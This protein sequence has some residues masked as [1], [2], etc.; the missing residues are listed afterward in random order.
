M[1]EWNEGQKKVLESLS[2]NTNILV[3]AAAG[4]G[5]TAV[6]VERI[7]QTLEQGKA[8]IDEIL[9]CT[10]TRAA[11]SQ[12]KSKI[13]KKL[14][15]L[16]SKDTDGRM[17]KQLT[18]A[19]SADIMTIDS[20]CGKI[21]RENFSLAGMD[22]AFEIYDSDEIAILKDEILD[23][24]F[25]E[26]YK[27]DESFKR[28][29]SFIVS[30]SIDDSELKQFILN[31]FNVSESYAY[32]EGWLKN[33]R[34]YVPDRSED[35]DTV[36]NKA[37]EWVRSQNWVQNYQKMY[38]DL[39][40]QAV[41]IFDE[42]MA[43]FANETDPDKVDLAKKL[44]DIYL[45]DM[46]NLKIFIKAETLKKMKEALPSKWKAFPNKK[47]IEKYGE[48]LA[49]KLYSS[50]NAIKE[51]F[52]G[53]SGEDELVDELLDS[54][55]YINTL[56]DVVE[57]FRT[58]L[59]AE[60]DKLKKY[61]FADIAHSAY[62]ILY[63]IEND[64]PSAVGRRMSEIY[65]YIY[66]DEYQDGNDLQENILNAVAR[67]TDGYISNVFM[68][69]DVKQSIYRFRLARPE[70]FNEKSRLYKEDKGG[71]LINLNMNYRSCIE[72]LNATN[73]IFRKIMTLEFGGIEY[74]EDVELK[75]PEEKQIPSKY[76]KTELLL[77]DCSE[78]ENKNDEIYTKYTREEIEAVEIGRRIKLLVEGDPENG[79]YPALIKNEN[80]DDK[81]PVSD[82]NQMFRSATYGDIVILQRKVKDS[83]AMVRIYEQMGIPVL[84]EDPSGYFDALEVSTMLSLL[85]VIDNVEQD[86]PFAAVLISPI[87][88]LTD[89]E[90]AL[91]VSLST[92]PKMSLADKCKLFAEGYISS[93][94]EGLKSIAEK[95]TGF[96]NKITEWKNI[97]PYIRIAKLID[98]VLKETGYEIYVSAMP[99]GKRRAANLKMLRVRA[100]QFESVRNA[101]LL[102]FLKFIDKCIVHDIDY[103]EA[104]VGVENSDAVRIMS[105]HKSKGLE[106]P[107]VFV[108][109]THRQFMLHDMSGKVA[110]DSDYGI[111][112]DSFFM[113]ENSIMAKKASA[114]KHIMSELNE[115]AVKT[116]EARLL[117]VAMTRAKEKLIISGTYSKNTPPLVNLSKCLLD[118]IRFV[119]DNVENYCIE[120]V[121]KTKYEVIFDFTKRY[122]KKSEDYSKD[123]EKL[124]N[125]IREGM[126]ARGKS[127]DNPYAYVYPYLQSTKTRSKM[128]VSEI[129]HQEMDKGLVVEDKGD[130]IITHVITDKELLNTNDDHK[131]LEN[132]LESQAS[133]MEKARERAALRGTIIHSLFEKM[134]YS[135]VNS[136]DELKKEFERVLSS[137]DHTPE[138]RSLINTSSL[139]KFYSSKDDS[140]FARM[141]KAHFER[142][143]YR[144]QQF[145]AGLGLNEIPGGYATDLDNSLNSYEINEDYTVIQGI[146]DAFFYEGDD[147]VLVDYKTDNVKDGE[148]LLGRYAS[149]MYLYA[150][151]LEKL[152]SA[153]VKDVILYSTR[154]G[155]VHYPEWRDYLK[156]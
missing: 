110:V 86:I 68:V 120:V 50:R 76:N 138:E 49:D 23:E 16:A 143:L 52:K 133:E 20:F 46:T 28:L 116:E 103:S 27:N 87:V 53:M 106:F 154:F 3:S 48:E 75:A 24:V 94:D 125:I 142:K 93:E 15:S 61:E 105:I 104:Q 101:G 41:R 139:A 40:L 4:S 29:A 102:D 96:L 109:R 72:V 38:K 70:L 19:Q 130:E 128:S 56:L 118:Y 59:R 145:I 156:K 99:D 65:K 89:S 66:I 141:K 135:L 51:Y 92:D 132:D 2:E 9:V 57:D 85:R 127:P 37:L 8:G 84:L 100:E 44:V 69:G 150:L 36:R 42:H 126:D 153:K 18:L 79:I 32:P 55:E 155:E 146:I 107:I 152:T 149:Q 122:I 45:D 62:K 83:T 31:I 78:D 11:A 98:T 144:E 64:C 12:M 97:R 137:D 22:P 39:A 34:C 131:T 90:L 119:L 136:Q 129:K 124:L 82:K 140:L 5:K 7:I 33:A 54:G 71:K 134:D 148:E 25:E 60:K 47:V 73:Y 95:L 114:K 63:D 121:N 6:L 74:D 123:V 67:K 113:L 30:R 108:S 147:I 80:Y 13:I 17:A 117:Y 111:A 91:I 10:F 151:T 1:P 112:M 115:I 26:H 81:K 77:I 58:Q 35:D 14:E 43:L 21:V 88:N